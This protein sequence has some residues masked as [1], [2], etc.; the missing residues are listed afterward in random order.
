M[1]LELRNVLSKSEIDSCHE[2]HACAL[3]AAQ[4]IGKRGAHGLKEETEGH[5]AQESAAIA[6]DQGIR[7]EKRYDPSRRGL[8][9]TEKYPGAAHGDDEAEPETPL[10]ARLIAITPIL[11]GEHHGAGAHAEHE[12]IQEEKDLIRDGHTRD[13]RRA[14]APNHHGIEEI[15]TRSNQILKRDGRAKDD[16]SAQDFLL[17]R[18]RSR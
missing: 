4:N 7:G 2:G 18:R 8:R 14:E 12:E 3:D 13:L 15:Q 1:R 17:F 6:D 16:E 5:D 10:N 11:R 9:R